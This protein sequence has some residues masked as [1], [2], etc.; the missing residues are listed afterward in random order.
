MKYLGGLTLIT[1]I[2]LSLSSFKLQPGY[3]WVP[4][5]VDRENYPRHLPYQIPP[6]Y[7]RWVVDYAEENGVPTSR[8]ARI[9]ATETTGHP[10]SI[11]WDP[12][13]VSWAG[14]IGLA[15]IMP[16]NLDMSTKQGRDF[17]RECNDGRP[18]DPRDPE[19]AIRVGLRHLAHMYR[20]TRSWRLA[21][22]VYNGGLGHLIDPDTYGPFWDESIDY[23]N[24]I[25]GTKGDTR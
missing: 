7:L 24:K 3:A 2:L 17:A 14:A 6:Q 25:L 16:E 22:M 21:L 10:T 19:T 18:I 13:A 15:Q 8:A 9:F 20:L 12:N 1:V 4:L 11:A 5:A 23:A